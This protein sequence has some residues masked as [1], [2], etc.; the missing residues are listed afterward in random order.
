[1]E[2][3]ASFRGASVA[4]TYIAPVL[5]VAAMCLAGVAGYAAKSAVG[6]G[7]VVTSSQAVHAAPGTVLRQDAQSQAALRQAVNAAPGTVLRQDNSSQGAAVLPAWIQGEIDRAASPRLSQD[8]PE[9]IGRYAT[10][11]Q[12]DL[13]MA[14]GYQGGATVLNTSQASERSTGHGQLP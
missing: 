2:A 10:H 13:L 4:Q 7:A 3:R 5:V 11:P 8:D 6:N 1:M 12:R 9:F 14:A